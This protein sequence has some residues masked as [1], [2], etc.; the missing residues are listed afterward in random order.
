[1]ARIVAMMVVVAL[2]AM[3]AGAL[4]AT[5]GGLTP[6]PAPE[7]P[8]LQPPPQEEAP[9]PAPVEGP[10]SEAESRIG[11]ATLL[12]VGLGIVAL[13]GGI[14]F[15]IARDARRMTGGRV[16]T[17]AAGGDSGLGAGGSTT[18]A[19]RRSRKLSSAERRR[20]RRGRAR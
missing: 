7:Q 8:L 14:W 5:G 20:R 1:M 19:A 13:I 9:A 6:Q 3:P 10:P 17:Q 2:A 15:A 12:L 16:R 11:P 4:G 18:R